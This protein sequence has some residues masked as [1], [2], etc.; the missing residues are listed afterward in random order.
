M[1]DC[2]CSTLFWFALAL[3]LIAA[4]VGITG[5]LVVLSARPKRD[6]G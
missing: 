2:C 4:E 1:T 6:P 3:G 5:L